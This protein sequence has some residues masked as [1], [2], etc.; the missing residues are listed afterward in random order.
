MI[1]E[2][3]SRLTDLDLHC[4]VRAYPGSAGLGLSK[5]VSEPALFAHT[6]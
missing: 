2:P 1:K 3:Y 5:P 6:W 4:K